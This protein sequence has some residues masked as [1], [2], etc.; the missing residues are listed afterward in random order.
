MEKAGVLNIKT[1]SK[2]AIPAGVMALGAFT[3]IAAG[4]GPGQS[5]NSDS[6]AATATSEPQSTEAPAPDAS[7]AI[8]VNGVE[9]PTNIS[10]SSDVAI[11][12]GKAHVEVSG[13]TT[14]ITANSQSESSDS[15]TTSNGNVHIK[16]DSQS[17]STSVNNRSTTNYSNH[18]TTST[19]ST[20]NSSVNISR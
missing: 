4:A 9:I 6:T 1:L 8:T 3:V 13:G 16:I 19:F 11:P 18:S 2:W 12:G 17:T 5:R 7:P 20:G 15:T 14:E 10:G